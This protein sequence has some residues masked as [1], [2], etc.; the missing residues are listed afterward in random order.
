MSFRFFRDQGARVEVYDCVARKRPE[1]R[2]GAPK[3]GCP[4]N[5]THF[6]TGAFHMLA[7]EREMKF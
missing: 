1:S 3:E 2:F 5:L 4:V 7:E 6:E